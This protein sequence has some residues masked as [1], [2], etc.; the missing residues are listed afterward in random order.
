MSVRESGFETNRPREFDTARNSEWGTARD[1]KYYLSTERFSAAVAVSENF[2]GT[3]WPTLRW[4]AYCTKETTTE[5]QYK[6][7]SKTFISA[8]TIFLLGGFL[9]CF[10]LPYVTNTCK[11]MKTVCHVC[12]H[13]TAYH[14]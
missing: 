5:I 9:G 10:L 6:N 11:D 4:C 8:A 13:E 3:E 2:E 12:K 14:E 1:S 7:S